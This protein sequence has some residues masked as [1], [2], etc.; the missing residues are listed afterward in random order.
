MENIKINKPACKDCI[1]N[2][3]CTLPSKI[4]DAESLISMNFNNIGRIDILSLNVDIKCS[5][6]RMKLNNDDKGD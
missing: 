3:V 4:K 1:H 5:E 6:Y 2:S